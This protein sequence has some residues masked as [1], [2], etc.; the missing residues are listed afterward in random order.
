MRYW[1][2]DWHLNSEIVRQTSHRPWKTAEEMNVALLKTV[3]V[4]TISDQIIH[5]GDLIQSGKDRGT[6]IAKDKQLT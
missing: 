1:T 3:V 5:V 4:K 2:S 6:E